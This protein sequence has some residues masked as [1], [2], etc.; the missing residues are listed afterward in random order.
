MSPEQPAGCVVLW[1][2][3]ADHLGVNVGL[4]DTCPVNFELYYDGRISGT[5]VGPDGQ[6]MSGSIAAFYAGPEKLNAAPVGS[7]VKNGYF[8]IQRLRPGRYRLLFLPSA[9]ERTST[10][11]VYYPGTRLAAEAVLIEVGDG[12]HVDGLHFTV[13]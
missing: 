7:Q 9:E 4:G 5:V 13:F 12:A 6:P 8:E 2:G 11:E 3:G 1:G 10:R